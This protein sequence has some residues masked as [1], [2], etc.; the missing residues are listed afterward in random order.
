MP[1]EIIKFYRETEAYGFFSNFSAHPVSLH[2]VVW[3]TTEHYFQAQK[4]LDTSWQERIRCAP[5]PMEA[6]NLGRA[7]PLRGD[8]EQVKEDVMLAALRAKFTQHPELRK[9]L[10]STKDTFLVEHTVRD[11]YWGDGGDGRGCNRLGVLLM[12][13][14]DEL[15]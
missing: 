1:N 13:V 15:S 11:R 7:V 12:R 5:T 6:K 2:G 14:R 9:A 3:P 8:W 4:T 10:L